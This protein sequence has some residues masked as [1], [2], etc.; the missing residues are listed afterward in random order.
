MRLR[1]LSFSPDGTILATGSEDY[2]VRLW[3]IH[4]KT[5]L[6]TLQGHTL[7]IQSVAFSPDS[8]TLA[9]LSYDGTILFWKIH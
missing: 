5:H 4:N 2:T 8:S 9:S 3:D 6:T 7:S 1:Q